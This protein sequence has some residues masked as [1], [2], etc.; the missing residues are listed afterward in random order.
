M[1]QCS[2]NANICQ[3]CKFD[4]A[5]NSVGQ[6]EPQKLR[7]CDRND[8]C[9]LN[10]YCEKS[11]HVCQACHPDCGNVSVLVLIN[12]HCARWSGSEPKSNDCSCK[13]GYYFNAKFVTCEKCH[14]ACAVCNGPVLISVLNAIQDIRC[15]DLRAFDA[16]EIMKAQSFL[17]CLGSFTSSQYSIKTVVISSCISAAI[18]F[19]VIFGALMTCDWYRKSRNAYQ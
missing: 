15:W 16:V 4:Y 8:Q 17:Q 12:A 19:I 13:R 5:L 7:P 3:V 1:R 10:S 2:K 18:L 11:G 14:I 9:P 6:C